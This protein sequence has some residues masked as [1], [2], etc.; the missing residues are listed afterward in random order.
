MHRLKEL[1]A[2]DLIVE[3]VGSIESRIQFLESVVDA[4]EN[5]DLIQECIP[6][7]IEL[8]RELFESIETHVGVDTV[9]ASSSS[10]ILP[11]SLVVGLKT[12]QDQVVVAHPGNPPHLIPVIEI[13]PTNDTREDIIDRANTIYSDANLSPVKLHKEIDGFVFNRLQGAVLR[14][15]YCLIRD[16]II[17]VEDLDKVMRDGLGR[18]W[19]FIGPFE[20]ADLNT[21]G[22]IASHAKKMGPAYRLM[23]NQRG[24]DDPWTPELVAEVERQRRAVLPEEQWEDRVEWRDQQLLNFLTVFDTHARESDSPA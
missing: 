22:G 20:T 21:R 17:S 19:V 16:G 13:V 12:V 6:E 14:E 9:I 3:P 11:S 23:G 15:A 7:Q 1:D 2:A 5:A 8:K 10:A 24:Q 18:R 4:I